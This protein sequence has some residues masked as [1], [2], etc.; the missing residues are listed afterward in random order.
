MEFSAVEYVRLESRTDPSVPEGTYAAFLS[1][2]PCKPPAK[3][4]AGSG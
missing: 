4:R 2:A 1:R 3:V